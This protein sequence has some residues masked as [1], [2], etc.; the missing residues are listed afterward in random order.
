MPSPRCTA[1]RMSKSIKRLRPAARLRK[2]RQRDYWAL[3]LTSACLLALIS[4]LEDYCLDSFMY[5]TIALLSIARHYRVDDLEEG[6][7]YLLPS[8][9]FGLPSSWREFRRLAGTPPGR[10]IA[11]A[12]FFVRHNRYSLWFMAVILVLAYAASILTSAFLDWAFFVQFMLVAPC[13]AAI[14]PAKAS[15]DIDGGAHDATRYSVQNNLSSLLRSK[16]LA[17]AWLICIVATVFI[18]SATGIGFTAFR[19]LDT[20]ESSIYLIVVALPF[21]YYVLALSWFFIRY[22][23]SAMRRGVVVRLV[24]VGGFIL[25]AA[26]IML[27]IALYVVPICTAQGGAK[28]QAIKEEFDCPKLM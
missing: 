1:S 22:S 16:S 24:N 23:S 11:A 2:M 20:F 19:N 7:D 9:P 10:V 8:G 14:Y 17:N 21:A 27:Y 15:T 12:I 3:I 5:L 4:H 26:L 6:N 13:I 18:T 25:I 28:V